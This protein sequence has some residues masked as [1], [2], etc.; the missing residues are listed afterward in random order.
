MRRFFTDKTAGEGEKILLEGGEARHIARVLRLG[1]GDTVLLFDKNGNEY[2]AVIQD[3]GK[4]D[5]EVLILRKIRP[6]RKPCGPDIVVAQAVLKSDKMDLVIQKCTE[7]GVSK[8][9]PFFSS[10]TIPKWSEETVEKK[11]RH[12]ENIVVASVK[13]SGARM[14]PVVDRAMEFGELI[15]C[16]AFDDFLKIIF[17]EKESVTTLKM[18]LKKV[19]TYRG[20]VAVV[21][22]EGG[23]TD[24]EIELARCCN[25]ITTGLGSHILRAETAAIAFLAILHYELT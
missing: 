21:G 7:I 22:P 13:Q 24:A 18:V 1:K 14:V 11:C 10:R 15:H 12:W 9:T 25:F 17:W 6:E 19:K 23:F 5:V 20:I 3:V 8:I 2:E 4:R 16:R